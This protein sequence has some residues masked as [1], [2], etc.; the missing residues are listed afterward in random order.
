MTGATLEKVCD[1]LDLLPRVEVMWPYDGEDRAN[2]REE[3]IT[4]KV[5]Y[6]FM[7]LHLLL[8]KYF[9]KVCCVSMLFR[10]SYF[11]THSIT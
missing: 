8:Q 11:G 1:F 10:R 9:K 7:G 2:L 6:V 5:E 4:I 3:R